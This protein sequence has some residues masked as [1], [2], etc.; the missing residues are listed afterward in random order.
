MVGF[1]PG[2]TRAHVVIC[3]TSWIMKG[4]NS[5]M[6]TTE[7]ELATAERPEYGESSGSLCSIPSR[8]RGALVARRKTSKLRFLLLSQKPDAIPPPEEPCRS[9]RAVPPPWRN[10]ARFRSGY[11]FVGTDDGAPPR[12]C[13]SASR[14]HAS[15]HDPKFQVDT[16]GLSPFPGCSV[17]W[18]ES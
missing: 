12:A 14:R 1:H 6:A 9:A 4:V 5:A 17:L 3:H 16:S 13:T 11:R 15:L 2:M 8:F 18:K 10:M 7:P